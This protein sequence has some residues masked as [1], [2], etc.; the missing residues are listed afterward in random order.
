MGAT[1]RST[2]C[3]MVKHLNKGEAK[4]ADKVGSTSDIERQA[5]EGNYGKE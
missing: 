3:G 1:S 4:S 2:A 5:S